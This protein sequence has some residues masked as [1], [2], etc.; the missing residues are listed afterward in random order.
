M[1][2]SDL[3]YFLALTRYGRLSTA[4]ERLDVGHTTVRR[5]VAALEKS[6]GERLFDKTVAGWSLTMAGQRLLPYATRIESE[7]DAA[8]A[9]LKDE[10]R[11][12]KG[13]VRIVTTDAMGS[14]VIAPGLASLQRTH[15]SI[16][17][18]LVTTSHLLNYAMG[19]FDIAVTIG[20]MNERRG[21]R[22]VHLCDYELRLYASLGY[23]ADN[24]PITTISDLSAHRMIWFVESLL[25]LPELRNSENEGIAAQMNIML[26]TTNVFAQLEATTA[27]AGLG[28]LPCFL[29]HEDRRLVPV[30]HDDVRHRRSFRMVIPSRLLNVEL[31]T[32]VATHL[33]A[34]VQQQ[35]Q[36]FIPRAEKPSSDRT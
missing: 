29:A 10:Q 3:R 13:T 1:D 4:A 28:L 33:F 27:G 30:L 24:P 23:L 26:R 14:M 15:P 6:I 12:V 36:R 17:V 9:A 19:E 35:R 18:D 20:D 7:A 25:Q 16:E 21:F 31:I 2:T 5:R 8:R 32:T 34:D 22:K 11:S